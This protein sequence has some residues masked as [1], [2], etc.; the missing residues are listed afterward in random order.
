MDCPLRFWYL[1]V[2]WVVPLWGRRERV[3]CHDEYQEIPEDF[4]P[5]CASYSRTKTAITET[6]IATYQGIS[7]CW[8]LL[9]SALRREGRIKTVWWPRPPDS[10]HPLRI[11]FTVAWLA[12]GRRLAL[13]LLA[14]PPICVCSGIVL[15]SPPVCA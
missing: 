12:R 6:Q 5:C 3:L 15:T 11:S 14:N 1:F 4:C 13:I 8:Y 2:R 7:D 9:S 10:G